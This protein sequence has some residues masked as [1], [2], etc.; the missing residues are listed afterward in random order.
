MQYKP[1]ILIIMCDQLN[2]GVLG[3]YK[4]QIPTPNIDKLAK[5]GALFTNAT[6]PFP[7]CSPSR[8][9]FITGVYPHSHGIIHNVMKRDYPTV[10]SPYTQEGIKNSD[11]T[12]ERMLYEVGY[13][14]HHFG[15][16]HLLDDD[17]DYY[18]DMFL[19]HY[20]YAE[21]MK[22]DF[23]KTRKQPRDTWMDWYGWALPIKQSKVY[24]ESVNAQGDLWKEE[25]YGEFI[26]KMGCLEYPVEKNFDFMVADKTIEAINKYTH[27]PFMITCSFNGPH[28]PNV[29]PSSYYEMFDPDQIQLPENYGIPEERYVSDWSRQIVTELGEKAVREFL[30]IYFAQVKL[31]DDQ[32]GRILK[33]LEE[34][35]TD[36]NTIIIFTADHGDMA[37]G[38]GMIWKSTHAFYDEV[39]RIPLIIKFPGKI[40]P[41]QVDAEVGLTDVMPTLLEF[42]NFPLPEFIQGH[43]LATY[44]K[45]EREWETSPSYSFCERLENNP[46]CIRN[47]QVKPGAYMIRGK[48]LKYFRY[49]DGEEY[50]YDLVNDAGETLNQAYNERYAIRKREMVSE[51]DSWLNRTGAIGV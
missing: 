50:M 4:G 26:A 36:D 1:N 8:A 9:S 29:I 40:K 49:T 14:T 7:M 51:L 12:T 23:I 41:G 33:S 45:G 19:E 42:S 30:R 31:I 10:I 21:V 38:H 35:G 47:V 13:K 18:N 6:C 16:W 17:P 5:E 43:S 46:G 3:C 28:D 44:L 27:L 22:E 24:Q 39:V 48:G 34:N 32:V 37:G 25:A 11:I 20:G 15:K 2:A